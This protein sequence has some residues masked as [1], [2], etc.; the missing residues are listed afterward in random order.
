MN[1]TKVI[2]EVKDGK[3]LCKFSISIYIFLIKKKSVT[4]TPDDMFDLLS[5]NFLRRELE[6]LNFIGNP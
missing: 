6:K 3:A 2:R 1:L 4:D 5:Q